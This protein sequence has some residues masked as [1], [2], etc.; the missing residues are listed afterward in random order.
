MFGRGE[1]QKWG[2]GKDYEAIEDSKPET[3]MKTMKSIREDNQLDDWSMRNRTLFHYQGLYAYSEKTTNHTKTYIHTHT[4][5]HIIIIINFII[6]III[7][8]LEV[9]G[10]TV[11]VLGNGNGVSSS[12][13]GRGYLRFTFALMQLER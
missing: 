12:S 1:V 9:G 5:T 3:E 6:S 10:R 11:I 7:I 13:P 8:T 2:I 4:H